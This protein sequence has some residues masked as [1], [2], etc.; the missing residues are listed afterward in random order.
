[1]QYESRSLETEDVK[2]ITIVVTDL[3]DRKR[4]EQAQWEAEQK[5][6]KMLQ[7]LVDGMVVVDLSGKITYANPAVE[8]ILNIQKEKIS[9]IYYQSG[10]WKQIDANDKPYP[11]DQLPLA[12]V[13]REQREVN[14]L[15]HGI[16]APGGEVKWLSVNASPLLDDKNQI[17]GAIA[18]FRDITEQKKGEAALRKLHEKIAFQ[19]SLLDQTRNAV[20]AT[21]LEGRIF[22][23]N[24]FAETLYQWKP[25]EVIGKLIN[26]VTVIR[27]EKGF[28]EKIVEIIQQIGYWEG[29]F[30][31]CRKDGSVFP[32]HV[33][34]TVIKDAEGAIIGML[35]VSIDITE[36][37]RVEEAVRT[38]EK[39]YRSLFENM[40]E[41]FAYCRMVYENNL[42]RDFIYIDVNSNFEQLTG[43]KNV[44]GKKVSEVVPGFQ[45]TNQEQLEIYGRVAS[46]GK[47]EKFDTYI[48]QLGM[49][50]SIAVYSPETGTFI[51]AFD[52]VTE[53]KQAEETLRDLEM[54]YRR[55]FEAA[56]DGVLLLD[57]ETGAIFDVNPYL[58]T[59]LGYSYEEFLGKRLWEIG[60]FTDIAANQLAFRELR[61]NDF[62]RYENL[63]LRSKD[64]RLNKC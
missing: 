30:N 20:I 21:D 63:P 41:G 38:S 1:M 52:N 6:D 7:S 32:A 2:G 8:R 11:P 64:G 57:A 48:E 47:P 16:I 31:V 51:A 23:W 37:K 54:R 46:T 53:R 62:I 29:E 17:Y 59:M 56:H 15:E 12:I 35:G 28:A 43:L 4:V 9:G 50:F 60:A 39:Q 33:V 45:S 58:V 49:W 14:A 18:S 25:E 19:A 44:V 5:L 3:T 34:D 40:L 26:E 22:Y 61:E 27:E 36:R 42:P 24:K 55:L 10:E 13:L